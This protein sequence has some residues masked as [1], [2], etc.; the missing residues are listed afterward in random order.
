MATRKQIRIVIEYPGRGGHSPVKFGTH[1]GSF[2]KTQVAGLPKE[3]WIL[4]GRVFNLPKDADDFNKR[5]QEVLP[6]AYDFNIHATA[7]VLPD[8]PAKPKTA[9]AASAPKP[10][11]KSSEVTSPPPQAPA[12][13]G[14]PE[15]PPGGNE[16]QE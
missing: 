6:H 15:T 10:K 14:P 2:I 1:G 16:K 8:A 11:S 5:C 13:I 3:I 9:K 12:L 4:D 7:R